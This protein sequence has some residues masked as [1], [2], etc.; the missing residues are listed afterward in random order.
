MLFN[1]SACACSLS[2]MN[3]FISHTDFPSSEDNM[4]PEEKLE[5]YRKRILEELHRITEEQSAFAK[6]ESESGLEFMDLTNDYVL[7]NGKMLR[8]ILIVAAYEAIEGK[9]NQEIFKAAA[10]VEICQSY[11]LAHDDIADKAAV[12]RGE[13]SYHHRTVGLFKK[14]STGLSDLSPDSNLNIGLAMVGGDYLDALAQEILCDTRLPSKRILKAIKAY[15]TTLKLTGY[16]QALDILLGTASM[17]DISEKDIAAIHKL[18]TASYTLIYPLQCGCYLAGGTDEQIYGLTEFGEKVG[19]GFQIVDDILGSGLTD[20][21][22]D[23][24][25]N[26]ISEGKKTLLLLETWRENQDLRTIIDRLGKEE[27]SDED[28]ELVK[29]A[30]K[31]IGVIE[32]SWSKAEGLLDEGLRALDSITLH[33]GGKDF[34]RYVGHR[35]IRRKK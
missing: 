16:G 19:I 18:K 23:K 31:E 13:P 29:N 2:H 15:S 32:R 20:D 5:V 7:N 26:D 17:N 14:R 22:S 33:P 10:S 9:V 8:G 1:G 27:V 21:K 6:S 4:K 35:L 34:L 25:K 11:L 30:M 3:T 12:R 28:I 24:T